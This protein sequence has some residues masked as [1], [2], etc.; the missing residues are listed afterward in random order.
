MIYV[1]IE[2]LLYSCL[3][4]VELDRLACVRD[5]YFSHWE[6]F[7]RKNLVVCCFFISCL[8]S[9]LLL[10]LMLLYFWCC[11]S[12]SGKWRIAFYL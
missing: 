7:L 6:E 12:C 10:L 8:L 4:I 5:F 1:D 2:I 9:L 3:I 11:S